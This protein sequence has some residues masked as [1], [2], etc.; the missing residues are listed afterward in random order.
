MVY[1]PPRTL[2]IF[3]LDDARFGL[4]ATLV[5]ESVWLPELTPVEEAPPY[6]A[7]IFNLRGQIV[8][9]SDLNLRFGHPARPYRLSDQIVILELDQLLMGLIVSE[10]REVIEISLDAIQPPPKFDGETYHHAHLV[11]GEVRVGDNIV[12]LLDV[13]QLVH[14]PNRPLP[15]PPP[16][17]EEG[18]TPP[19]QPSPAGEGR[20]NTPSLAC[21]AGETPNAPPPPLAGEGWGG[22]MHF[23]PEATPEEHAIFHAR[24][25][26]LME[27]AAEEEGARLPLAVVELDGEYFGIELGAIQEFCDIASPCPIPCCPQHILGAISLR[28]NLF[29]LL[30]LRA[31]LNL[32]RTT[33]GGGKVVVARASTW[34]GTGLGEQAVGV[35]VDQV[36]DVIYLREEALQAAPAALRE[37]HG[38][39]VKGTAPYGGKMMAVLDLPALLAREEWIVNESV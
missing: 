3:D 23:C 7:G 10:V 29:T 11:A 14:P 5:R 35:A 13:S 6:I 17:A 22:G 9:V 2:L 15:S 37:Q 33:Q 21:S 8:P 28:G 19:S 1:S 4:D 34:L 16:Q 36:H 31:A 27:A 18:T 32:P 25:K 38:A 30:D 26:A 39:E 24:A 20:S 12:T